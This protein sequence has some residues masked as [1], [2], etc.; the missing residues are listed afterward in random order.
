MNRSGQPEKAVSSLQWRREEPGSFKFMT[1]LHGFKGILQ[2]KLFCSSV[3][4]FTQ[5]L[6]LITLT[7]VVIKLCSHV[8][9]ER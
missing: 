1:G 7:S 8:I 9:V 2:P 4:S 6:S 3:V 5:S